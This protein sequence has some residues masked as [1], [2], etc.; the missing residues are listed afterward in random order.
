M[1]KSTQLVTQTSISP[2]KTVVH[3]QVQ[4]FELQLAQSKPLTAQ[5]PEQKPAQNAES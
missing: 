1:P 2:S 3:Q 5:P 4:A